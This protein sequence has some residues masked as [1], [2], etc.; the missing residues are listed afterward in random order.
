MIEAARA[1]G[2]AIPGGLSVIGFNNIPAA[3]RRSFGL[4]TI[5]YP[6]GRVVTEIMALL[7]RRLNEPAAPAETRRIPVGLVVRDTTRRTGA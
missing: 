5:D 1:L 2:L 7:D 3:A 6:V 4:T